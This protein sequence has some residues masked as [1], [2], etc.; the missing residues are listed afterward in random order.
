MKKE[1]QHGVSLISLLIASAI[2][3]VLS[4]YVAFIMFD[5]AQMDLRYQAQ[6]TAVT[7]S[8]FVMTKMKQDVRA[9]QAITQPNP[10]QTANEFVISVNGEDIHYYIENEQLIREQG[11]NQDALTSN[12]AKITALTAKHINDDEPA[13]K[14]SLKI[15][16]T[17][18]WIGKLMPGQGSEYSYE[19]T[20]SLR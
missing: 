2:L 15:N 19:T 13:N 6:Q 17:I 7:N 18:E 14:N 11:V 4:T 12:Q 10:S 9:A 20:V 8:R 1:K 3:V 5:L 16:F